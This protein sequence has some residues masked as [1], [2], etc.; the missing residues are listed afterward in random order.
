MA[1]RLSGSSKR[2]DISTTNRGRRSPRGRRR[3]PACRRDAS[4]EIVLIGGLRRLSFAPMPDSLE[5]LKSTT[6]KLFE[7]CRTREWKG[8]DPYDAL[9]SEILGSL[10]M[11]NARLPRLV[12]TQ[13]LKRSEERRV[14]K[15]CRSRWS[16]Y[17]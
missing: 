5:C 6:L 12:L 4:A 8:H 13:L 16:P 3:H 17:H 7:Y 11:L 15:E 14:G 9:N 10:P 2:C 1:R